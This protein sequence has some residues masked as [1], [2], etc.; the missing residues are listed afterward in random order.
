[1]ARR[2][3]GTALTAACAGAFLLAAL[4][5]VHVALWFL[6]RDEVGWRPAVSAAAIAGG[7]LLIAAALALAA[8]RSRPGTSEIEALALRQQ[9]MDAMV[10]GLG[11][12]SLVL[13]LLRL[14]RGTTRGRD[15]RRGDPPHAD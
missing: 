10:G 13:S 1:M 9:A 8:S 14:W 11:R 12:V 6:L 7:D 5:F 3:A 4:A 15:V 2:L